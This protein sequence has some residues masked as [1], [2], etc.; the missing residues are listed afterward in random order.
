MKSQ[1]IVGHFHGLIQKA[2]KPG[3]EMHSGLFLDTSSSHGT[4]ED[5]S[6][7]CSSVV[8]E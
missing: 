5:L 8:S 6:C 1:V 2:S 4:K 7:L 3:D